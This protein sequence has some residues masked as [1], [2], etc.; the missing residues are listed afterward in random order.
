MPW[1]FAETNTYKQTA[2]FEYDT[3]DS[4]WLTL[5]YPE[6]ITPYLWWFPQFQYNP[7]GTVFYSASPDLAWWDKIPELS[8]ENEQY[9]EDLTFFKFT[10]YNNPSEFSYLVF[11][12]LETNP[13]IPLEDGEYVYSTYEDPSMNPEEII[14]QI[15]DP[16]FTIV[17]IDN[18]LEEELTIFDVL[19]D[20]PSL[21]ET[22]NNE[23]TPEKPEPCVEGMSD[24]FVDCSPNTVSVPEYSS[25]FG[26]ILLGTAFCCGLFK[27]KRR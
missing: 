16:S 27:R 11:P 6:Q 19:P 10:R 5:G 14:E 7:D 17:G 9:L 22:E 26:F 18:D 12:E 4:G 23:E 13:F 3:I 2:G 20:L 8:G 25:I 1:L 21:E 24:P 15:L